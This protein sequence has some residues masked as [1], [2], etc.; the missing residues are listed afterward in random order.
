MTYLWARSRTSQGWKSKAHRRASDPGHLHT[1][2]PANPGSG[3]PCPAALRPGRAFLTPRAP[4]PLRRPDRSTRRVRRDRR[5]HSVATEDPG[6]PRFLTPRSPRSPR[7]FCFPDC[8]PLRGHRSIP[9]SH[10]RSKLQG[11]SSV[12]PGPSGGQSGRI[13]QAADSKPSIHRSEF[14]PVQTP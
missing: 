6:R 8:T 1:R 7:N 4:R 11:V 13:R 5:G 10:H 9:R 3:V 2:G 14:Q 12:L